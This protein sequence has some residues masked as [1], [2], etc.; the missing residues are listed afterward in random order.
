MAEPVSHFSI[1]PDFLFL[2]PTG[3]E[4]PWV[5][6]QEHGYFSRWDCL[7]TYLQ[8]CPGL[9]RGVVQPSGNS[10]IAMTLGSGPTRANPKRVN[11]GSP[12]AG[13]PSSALRSS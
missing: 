4:L 1:F 2:G 5:F 7:F 6:V 8:G 11:S 13:S 9:S 12:S 3:H 10:T